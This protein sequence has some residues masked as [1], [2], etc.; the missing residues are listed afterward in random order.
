[1]EI[2][3]NAQNKIATV[4]YIYYV[5][6]CIFVRHILDILY[7][8]I[9][10]CG[11]SVMVAFVDLRSA[12]LVYLEINSFPIYWKAREHAECGLLMCVGYYVFWTHI[13]LPFIYNCRC[14][15]TVQ[16]RYLRG[17]LCVWNT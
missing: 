14:I 12:S 15:Y 2:F 16:Q 1:M 8:H 11:L 6:L 5:C 17:T 3:L 4:L 9:G 10:W 7:V 13:K